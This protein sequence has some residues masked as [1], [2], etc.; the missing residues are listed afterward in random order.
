M[1][2]HGSVLV[3]DPGDEFVATMQQYIAEQQIASAWFQ[4]IG[5]FERSMIA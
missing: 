2:A 5:A 4:A 1:R 3:F